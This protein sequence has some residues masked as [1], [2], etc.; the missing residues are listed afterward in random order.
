MPNKV[1]TDWS[2]VPVLCSAL[3]VASILGVSKTTAWRK[4]KEGSLPVV[5]A[6]GNTYVSKQ[7]LMNA[8]GIRPEHMAPEVDRQVIHHL[9]RA[10]YH[11]NE[12]MRILE[13]I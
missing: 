1:I 13:E 3:D 12:A 5:Y 11:H 6:G 10:Q 7:E 2:E 9:E 8:L 4:M